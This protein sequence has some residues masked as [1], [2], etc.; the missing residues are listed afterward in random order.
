MRQGSLPRLGRGDA[1][2]DQGTLNGD[3]C[4]ANKPNERIL[5][6][7]EAVKRSSVQRLLKISF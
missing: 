1:D 3:G 7:G 6:E 5:T 4:L 2:G